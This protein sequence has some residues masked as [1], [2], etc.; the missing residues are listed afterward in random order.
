MMASDPTRRRGLRRLAAV[1]LG[2]GVAVAVA[3][4]L[5]TGG[6]AVPRPL[7]LDA[8]RSPAAV[9]VTPPTTGGAGSRSDQPDQPDQPEVSQ[10]PAPH[11]LNFAQDVQGPAE[12]LAPTATKAPVPADADGCGH[13]YGEVNQCVPRLFP[14]EVPATAGARCGWLLARGFHALV[15]HAKDDLGLDTNHDGVACDKGDEGVPA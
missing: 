9:A 5:S 7:P 11:V 3:V 8:V 6:D 2:T 1:V 12:Q 13:A 4:M 10:A 15:L 14:A